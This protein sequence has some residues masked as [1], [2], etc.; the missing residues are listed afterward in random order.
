[1][2]KIIANDL[3]QRKIQAFLPPKISLYVK[4]EP[5]YFQSITNI[6]NYFMETTKKLIKF[7]NFYNLCSLKEKEHFIFIE[8]LLLLS[9]MA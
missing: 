7:I 3:G 1:M 8:A 4:S 9:K 2:H 6:T 5:S